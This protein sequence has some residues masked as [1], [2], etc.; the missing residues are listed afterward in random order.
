MKY[1]TIYKIT[2]QLNNY[3]YIGAHCT[4]NLNDNYMGSGTNIKYAIKKYGKHNFTKEI[5]FIFNNIN[6]MLDKEKELVNEDFIARTDT[7]NIILG[8]GFITTNCVVVKDKN[9]KVFMT[10]I[11]DPRY[12]SGELISNNKNL[13]TAKDIN[14]NVYIISKN[15]PRWKNGELFGNTKNQVK[16]IDIHG[17]LYRIYNNDSRLLTGELTLYKKLSNTQKNI[18]INKIKKYKYIDLNRNIYYIEHDKIQTDERI[19]SNKIFKITTGYTIVKDINNNRYYLPKNDIK[20]LNGEL[21]P[22]NKKWKIKKTQ[23]FYGDNNSIGGKIGITNIITFK[24]KYVNQYELDEYLSNNW[25][26][27]W[28]KK[29]NRVANSI[30]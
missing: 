5:L 12:I 8:S 16:A 22:T 19:L 11:T 1:Y 21:I 13:I 17:N 6:D 26:I 25:K 14:N 9:D 15:D 23:S 18:L 3:I 30:G 7:Y 29:A 2:N 27:G 4:N 24:R 10:H 28:I 20:I